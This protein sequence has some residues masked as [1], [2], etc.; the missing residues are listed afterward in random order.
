MYLFFFLK[1]WNHKV[2]R[3]SGQGTGAFNREGSFIW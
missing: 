3:R 2:E 1:F